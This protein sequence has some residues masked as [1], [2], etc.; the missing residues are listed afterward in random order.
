MAV[1]K[2]S[3]VRISYSDLCQQGYCHQQNQKEKAG[4]TASLLDIQ[5]RSRQRQLDLA[6]TLG[7]N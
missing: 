4:L 5:G 3:G 2:D 7:I 1:A 6:Q